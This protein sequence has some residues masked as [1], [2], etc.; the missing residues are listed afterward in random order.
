[1][2]K[3]LANGDLVPDDDPRAAGSAHQRPNTASGGRVRNS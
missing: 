2:V 3:V 1:M